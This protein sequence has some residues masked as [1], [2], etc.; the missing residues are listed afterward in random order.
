M[1][2]LLLL[3]LVVVV[4]AAVVV[5]ADLQ[6]VEPTLEFEFELERGLTL[7]LELE[8]ALLMLLMLLLLVELLLEQRGVAARLTED[9]VAATCT[10]CWRKSFIALFLYPHQKQL[11]FA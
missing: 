5:M 7:A 1:M 11:P 4:A 10:C 9:D 8:L 6:F 2:L 3:L